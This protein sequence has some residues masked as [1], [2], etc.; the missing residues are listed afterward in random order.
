MYVF[1]YSMVYRGIRFEVQRNEIGLLS[2]N[3]VRITFTFNFSFA[4]LST[5]SLSPSLLYSSPS[6]CCFAA[7]TIRLFH[8]AIEK[9]KLLC[10]HLQCSMLCRQ[11]SH[12]WH[13]CSLSKKVVQAEGTQMRLN[14]FK[15]NAYTTRMACSSEYPNSMSSEFAL[16][17]PF[18]FGKLEHSAL[19]GHTAL[20][21][22]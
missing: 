2:E 21:F 4:C 9:S 7:C 13:I 20:N 6:R 10:V 14:Q 12:L 16:C 17:V 15:L 5:L 1:V 3:C 22:S 8:L 11:K 18:S 19:M